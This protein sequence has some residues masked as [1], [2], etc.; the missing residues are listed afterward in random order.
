MGTEYGKDWRIKVETAV[1]DTFIAIGGETSFDWTRSSQEVDLSD[2]DSG[3]YGSKS[4][5]QQTVS[6]KVNGNLKLPDAGLERVNTIAKS[7]TPEVEIQVVKG[8]LVKYRGLVGIG[9]F[10]TSHGKDGTVTYTFDMSN[11]GA[12]VTDDLGAAA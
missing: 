1:A 3:T 10:S 6:F 9:N 2:K 8:A 5:G 12:P 7:G 11:I 4:F